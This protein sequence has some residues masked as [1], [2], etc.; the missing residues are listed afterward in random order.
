MTSY[1]SYE[2]H[3]ELK[4]K[5]VLDPAVLGLEGM[6]SCQEEVHYKT[7]SKEGQVDIVFRNRHGTPY[8]VELTTSITEKARRRVRKQIKRAKNYFRN[9]IG[10]TVIQRENELLL[11]WL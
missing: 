9:A 2:K 8:L 4:R 3:E 7:G 10:I 6:V 11:G 1:G 5:L